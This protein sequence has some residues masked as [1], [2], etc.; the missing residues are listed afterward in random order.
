MDFDSENKTETSRDN[1]FDR[2][3]GERKEHPFTTTTNKMTYGNFKTIEK[4]HNLNKISIKDKIFED[5]FKTYIPSNK[6]TKSKNNGLG[7]VNNMDKAINTMRDT[8]SSS[9]GSKYGMDNSSRVNSF[10]S[11]TQVGGFVDRFIPSYNQKENSYWSNRI[12]KGNLY[13]SQTGRTHPN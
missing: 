4:D 6:L 1:T 13:S 10:I 3:L 2:L 9:L 12:E 5:F 7:K 8:N 11:N